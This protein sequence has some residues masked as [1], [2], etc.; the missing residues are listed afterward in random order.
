MCQRLHID[1]GNIQSVDTNNT[2]DIFIY[3]YHHQHFHYY[4]YSIHSLLLSKKN[5]NNLPLDPVASL[6]LLFLFAKL[7]HET[8]Q[9][10]RTVWTELKC[11]INF[12]IFFSDVAM[13]IFFDVF[14]HVFTLLLYYMK[15]N[16]CTF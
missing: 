9:K 5:K 12:I 14:F 1:G 6:L 7:H 11:T 15:Y 4:Y 16:G 8:I 10:I 2:F 3:I 13:D